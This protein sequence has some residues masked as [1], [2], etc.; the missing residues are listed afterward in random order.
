M[1]DR[2]EMQEV[3][4]RLYSARIKSDLEEMSL[5]FCANA[6]FRILGASQRSPV[7]ILADGSADVR[8]TLALLLRISK[9]QDYEQIA[10]IIDGDSAAVHWKAT[11]HSR[12]TPRPVSTEFVDIVKIFDRRISS[13]TELFAPRAFARTPIQPRGAITKLQ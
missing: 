7:S 2:T 11:V 3:L 8:E 13:F 5:L 10:T 12:V 4:Q 6:R 9:L 1:T